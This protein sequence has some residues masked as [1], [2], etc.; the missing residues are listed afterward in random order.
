MISTVMNVSDAFAI[1]GESILKGYEGWIDVVG[2]N[3]EVVVP[4]TLDKASNSRTKGQPQLGDVEVTLQMN[5]AYPKLLEACSS[6]T[7]LGNVKLVSLRVINGALTETS[8][9][10]LGGVY[11][12]KVSIVA[13]SDLKT[14]TPD[15]QGDP[16]PLVKVRLNYLSI[17]SSYTAFDNKG[18]SRGSVAS[19]TITATAA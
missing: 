11:I 6:A 9:Y 17:V 10:Q 14:A 18:H 12:A 8:H 19:K 15:H 2:F 3:H 13:G 4:M 1:Q 5:K 16:I 7:N